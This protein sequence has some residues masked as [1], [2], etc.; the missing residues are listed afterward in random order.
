MTY[1]QVRY[2]KTNIKARKETKQLNKQTKTNSKV[3][4][5]TLIHMLITGVNGLTVSILVICL[6]FVL[7]GHLGLK[8]PLTSENKTKP[9]N[10]THTKN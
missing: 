10:N 7:G 9:K 2:Y 4:V 5:G 1:A 3:V 8:I 6:S